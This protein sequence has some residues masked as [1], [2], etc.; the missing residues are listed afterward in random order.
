MYD[1]NTGGFPM[2]DLQVS[3]AGAAGL[4]TNSKTGKE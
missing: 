2:S 4:P 3:E 1:D